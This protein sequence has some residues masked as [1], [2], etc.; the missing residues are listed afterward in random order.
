M[1]TSLLPSSR[2]SAAA[3]LVALPL[4]LFLSLCGT[5]GNL[6]LPAHARAARDPAPD[7]LPSAP[8]L[9]RRAP[10]GPPPPPRPPPRG[11]AGGRAGGFAPASRTRLANDG[12]GRGPF[13]PG[14]AGTASAAGAARRNSQQQAAWQQ[15][16]GGR[17]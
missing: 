16:A 10:P 2:R 9:R 13:T 3:R 8:P 1:A 11:G 6:P 17:R 5:G 15:R 7:E 14:D 4:F 12:T